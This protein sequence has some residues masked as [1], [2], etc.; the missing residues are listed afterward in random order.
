MSGK[1]LQE[2]LAEK[3][4]QA[5][6]KA[7]DTAAANA[8]MKEDGIRADNTH[9]LEA[10][11][12]IEVPKPKVGFKMM[13][14]PFTFNKNATRPLKPGPDGYYD[15]QNHEEVLLLKYHFEKGHIDFV[16]GE[17]K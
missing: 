11:E 16:S 1:S 9:L 2:Q 14:V 4:A 15:P 3:A 7:E 13:A 17:E 6:A 8:E 12:T 5:Q 10:L